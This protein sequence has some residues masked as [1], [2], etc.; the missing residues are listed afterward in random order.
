MTITQHTERLS[1]AEADI[2]V[3]QL[4]GEYHHQHG[5]DNNEHFD[6][7]ARRL[8]WQIGGD[9]TRDFRDYLVEA[10]E[11]FENL[12]DIYWGDQ[13]HALRD[14]YEADLNTAVNGAL[15]AAGAR[16]GVINR[17]GEQRPLVLQSAA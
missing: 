13:P 6:D 17:S 12:M 16:S 15:D 14:R 2:V 9:N 1:R 4:T 5:I 11:A 3:R 7:F 10:L 8:A